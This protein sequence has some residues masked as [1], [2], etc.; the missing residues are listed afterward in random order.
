[1]SDKSDST[2]NMP[3]KRHTPR[4]VV[5]D[6]KIPV[7]DATRACTPVTN[8]RRQHSGYGPAGDVSDELNISD[9][10]STL[11]ERRKE[12]AKTLLEQISLS[13]DRHMGLKNYLANLRNQLQ[14]AL[15]IG[16]AE[17]Q[18]KRNAL[19]AELDNYLEEALNQLYMSQKEKERVLKDRDQE[20]DC[21]LKEINTSAK[22]LQL[23]IKAEPKAKFVQ[24]YSHTVSEAEEALEIWA[25][26][27]EFTSDWATLNMPAFPYTIAGTRSATQSL[28]KVNGLSLDIKEKFGEHRLLPDISESLEK[29]TVALSPIKPAI[30]PKVKDAGTN[31]Q[32]TKAS[33]NASISRES[34]IDNP[35]V[36]YDDEDRKDVIILELMKSYRE[37][38]TLYQ[39]ARKGLP[40][41]K[42]VRPLSFRRL[43][44]R[45][46]EEVRLTT[47]EIK[48]EPPIRD[49]DLSSLTC[50]DD[51]IKQNKELASRI[52]RLEKTIE[53][54]SRRVQI[55]SN[56][57]S[58][59]R[60][61]IR[62][63]SPQTYTIEHSRP[64]SYRTGLELQIPVEGDQT[65]VSS[66][67]S[68][69][70]ISIS[71]LMSDK[72]ERDTDV[73][74]SPESYRV[75]IP[76]GY[77]PY[78][79]YYIIRIN[80]AVTT[81]ELL[82]SITRRMQ[83]EDKEKYILTFQVSRDAA[84]KPFYSTERPAEVL[85]HYSAQGS[86]AWPRVYLKTIV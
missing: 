4:P 15:S 48:E 43:K 6:A 41:P 40:L 57:S 76:Q 83:L 45:V 60:T 8:Y 62:G 31:P 19:V 78:S 85:K 68:H 49:R 33:K 54:D 42:H 53:L 10:L 50:T 64:S 16:V 82:N 26:E 21:Y 74:D 47:D 66:R 28:I 73:Y 23:K 38:E 3:S 25:P 58:Q 17:L 44:E 51:L 70:R 14:Q 71:T 37:L 69:D 86:Q 1:V 79:C 13:K 9:N 11:Y 75:Y 55:F 2:A 65:V 61:P 63:I 29:K 80:P 35:S 20:V 5:R 56:R 39:W 24:N 59:D 7:K 34:E 18:N 30:E 36:R 52:E 22:T 72:P 32:T 27:P 81:D 12:A 67:A 84:Q 77:P 46:E